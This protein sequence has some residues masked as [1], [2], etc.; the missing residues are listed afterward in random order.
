M[1]YDYSRARPIGSTGDYEKIIAADCPYNEDG[2]RAGPDDAFK[3]EYS[4][5]K[6]DIEFAIMEQ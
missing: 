6:M 2:T 1:K 4:G 3:L 5:W